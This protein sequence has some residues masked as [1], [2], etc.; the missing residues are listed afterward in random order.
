M[1]EQAI[2]M[3][4][5]NGSGSRRLFFCTRDLE[6]TQSTIGGVG[7]G[8]IHGYGEEYIHYL[9]LACY[10]LQWDLRHHIMRVRFS[11]Y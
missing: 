6:D 7:I 10:M 3:F 11:G 4:S 1:E 2:V 9:L 5:K 8:A